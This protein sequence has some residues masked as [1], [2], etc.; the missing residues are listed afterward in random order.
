MSRGIRQ[1]IDF[2]KIPAQSIVIQA[3]SHHEFIWNAESC[4]VYRKLVLRASGL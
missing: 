3:I 2:F 1:L 4:I